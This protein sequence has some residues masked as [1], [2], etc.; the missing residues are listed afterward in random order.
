MVS[1][2]TTTG[3]TKML[4]DKIFKAAQAIVN[5]KAYPYALGTFIG[6]TYAY[7]IYRGI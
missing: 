4:Q 3:D 7:L 2:S 5:S 1:S 6:F